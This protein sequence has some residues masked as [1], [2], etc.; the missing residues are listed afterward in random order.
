MNIWEAIIQGIVQGLTEFLPVSSSG[1]LS[2]V[3][4]ILP[5]TSSGSSDVGNQT[6]SLFLHFGTL[7]AVFIVYREI[8]WKMI[9]EFF[10][11]CKELFTGKFSW[12]LDSMNKER[13]MVIFVVVASAFAI[14]LFLP[15]LGWLGLETGGEPVKNLSD[16]SE[17][18]S[19]DGSIMAEGIFFTFTGIIIL[20]ATVF[21]Y[22][23]GN[24]PKNKDGVITMKNA[25]A[26]G[27]GQCIAAMPGISRSG[28]TTTMGM[29]TGAEKNTALEFS[30]IMGIPAILA[31]NLLE[32]KDTD[33]SAVSGATVVSIIV[34]I[35]VS[36][37]VGVLAI[38]FLKWIVSNEK[39]HYFGYYCLILGVIVII[40]A[41]IESVTGVTFSLGR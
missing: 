30:F 9:L 33:W 35:V 37:V 17:Y 41:T 10:S 21:D 31:A 6:L 36:A 27:L 12:K 18:F 38:K 20:L 16:L 19:N 29:L 8:I 1:H 7:L 5:S 28:T 14:L 11:M 26:M 15:V 25:C 32:V 3:Q 39:F 23:I 24:A 4:H 2:L 22:R 34:G 40:I 13:R